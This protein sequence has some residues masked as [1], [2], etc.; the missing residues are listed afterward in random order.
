MLKVHPM[1]PDN[2]ST[3]D[4]TLLQPPF[5]AQCARS[6]LTAAGALPTAEAAIRT[7]SDARRIFLNSDAFFIETRVAILFI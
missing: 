1:G 2:V 4:H 7:N 3:T 5:A 6:T